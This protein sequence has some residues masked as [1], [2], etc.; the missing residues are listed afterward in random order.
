LV[1]FLF[2]DRDGGPDLSQFAGHHSDTFPRML[3]VSG[4]KI[5]TFS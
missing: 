3:R 4:K 2:F 5:K 1:G